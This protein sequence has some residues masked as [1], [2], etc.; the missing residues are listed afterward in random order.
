MP[1]TDRLGVRGNEGPS[2]K[3]DLIQ[4]SR[5][6]QLESERLLQVIARFVRLS[7]K[8]ATMAPYREHGN[9]EIDPA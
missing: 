1:A 9:A 8:L 6:R 5:Y 4:A 7:G 3:P 2:L